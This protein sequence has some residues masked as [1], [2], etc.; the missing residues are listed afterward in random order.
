[1][2]FLFGFQTINGFY[3]I[4]DTDENPILLLQLVNVVSFMLMFRILK[5]IDRELS[6]PNG[7]GHDWMTD[8]NLP[9]KKQ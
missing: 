6:L 8:E 4:T 1:M 5:M 7:W 2:F 3:Y 9:P